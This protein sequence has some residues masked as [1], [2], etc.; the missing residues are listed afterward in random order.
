MLRKN[1]NKLEEISREFLW[2]IE[3]IPEARELKLDKRLSLVEVESEFSEEEDRGIFNILL[4]GEVE[5]FERK[6]YTDYSAHS[7]MALLEILNSFL[8]KEFF[9]KEF[10]LFKVDRDVAY[11][12]RTQTQH[13]RHDACNIVF[14][15]E[16]KPVK[17]Y[18]LQQ[19]ILEASSYRLGACHYELSGGI[20]SAVYTDCGI[21]EV[22]DV[23][24]DLYIIH[25]C[26]EGT[27]E[28]YVKV[29]EL[30]D[31]AWIA[32]GFEI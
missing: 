17:D 31:D 22:Q 8:E 30:L 13:N 5:L 19:K 6:L 2:A 12:L 11:D 21:A 25:K 10:R 20:L 4:D 1:Y 29:N 26:E 3:A 28:E 23:E 9:R 7:V 27:E 18:E 16:Y 14:A 15:E 32:K 24:G